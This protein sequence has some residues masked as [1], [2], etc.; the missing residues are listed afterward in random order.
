MSTPDVLFRFCINWR[1]SLGGNFRS[2]PQPG[3]GE[4]DPQCDIRRRFRDRQLQMFVHLG[5]AK[6]G[7]ALKG[8]KWDIPAV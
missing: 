3:S 7:R 8:E 4:D 6:G 5:T 1:V 2:I